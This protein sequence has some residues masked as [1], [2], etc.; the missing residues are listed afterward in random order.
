M[1][2]QKHNTIILPGRSVQAP[3]KKP[4][5]KRRD[6]H[7]IIRRACGVIALAELAVLL[8]ANPHLYVTKVQINGLQTLSTER[9]FAEAH[10]PARSNI[11]LLA[12][13]APFAARL[14]RDPVIDHVTRTIELP[15]TLVLNVTE[16][17]PYATLAV[18]DAD[19]GKDYWLLDK[20]AVPFRTFDA[21]PP[22]VPLLEWQGAAPAGL[23]L[24][25]PF[26]DDRLTEAYALLGLVRDK[27][28]L[29]VQKIKVDQNAN[30][31]L[32][33]THNLQI[34]L[35]QPDALPQ[36]IA[37]AQ[38]AVG[39]H[40]GEIARRAACIDVSC[41]QQPVYTLRADDAGTD[42]HDDGARRESDGSR[43]THGH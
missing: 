23:A 41:P 2:K 27:K 6:W 32:N 1:H 12:L 37:L 14:R 9:V 24:G 7:K 25:R 11:F 43:S 31:C 17:Q 33:S 36:K 16:R 8:F 19:G 26:R 34:K 15:H 13:R 5:R 35:G 4:N 42:S 39:W 28:N 22:R 10:V 20:G 21:P 30:L 29:G 18:A 38:A 3:K 40:E